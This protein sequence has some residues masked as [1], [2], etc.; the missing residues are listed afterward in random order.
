MNN[1][2]STPRALFTLFLISVSFLLPFVLEDPYVLHFMITLFIWSILTLGIR[3]LLVAGQLNAAH[4]SFMG[5]G[6][7]MSA[8]MV[9]K[10]GWS[11]WICLPLAGIISALL[12]L[13]IGFPILRIKGAYFVMATFAITEVFK[14]IW[15]MW[16]NVFGGP[17]GLLGVPGPDPIHIAGWTI[18]FTTKV[19]FYYLGLILFLITLLV[20]RRIDKSRFGMAL[21]AISQTESFAESLGVKVIWYKVLAFAAGSFFAGIAGAF[22]AHYTAYVSPWDFSIMSS[23]Y[24]VMYAVIGGM[25]SFMGPVLGCFV[26]LGIDEMLRPLET[27]VP[28]FFGSVLILVLR[29]F[30]GGIITLPGQI[31]S[32]IQRRPV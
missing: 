26:L 1:S 28:I 8:L 12:A 2:R 7:Y 6:A 13:C 21:R 29:F 19:P 18:S 25:G 17:Q 16:K 9:M 24:M 10:L 20:I 14:H 22:W 30:P 27:Y 3:I 23:L 31:R 11:F 15:M 4:A 32:L 5:M